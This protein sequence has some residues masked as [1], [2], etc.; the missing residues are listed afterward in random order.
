MA[1]QVVDRQELADRT[2]AARAYTQEDEQHYIRYLDDCVKTSVDTMRE[3]RLQQDECWRVFNEE[4]P[5]NFNFKELWQSRIVYPKPYKL[6]QTGMAFVRKAF[7]V[8]FL[9]VENET[10]RKAADFWES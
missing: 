3:I 9:S 1:L 4:E 6:V 2:E 8:D 10:D 7:D 5:R